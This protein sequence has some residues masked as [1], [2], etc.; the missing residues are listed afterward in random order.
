MF[1]I[2][3]HKL[4]LFTIFILSPV[5]FHISGLKTA[6]FL[7]PKTYL[8]PTYETD[9]E[10]EWVGKIGG[11]GRYHYDFLKFTYLPTLS[12]SRPF[13]FNFTQLL[14]ATQLHKENRM[15]QLC[16]FLRMH[17]WFNCSYARS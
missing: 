11:R 2:F 13:L 10:N 5:L 9:R 4:N 1:T 3:T 17:I 8:R 6:A 7:A 16:C 12:S 14:I 15:Y